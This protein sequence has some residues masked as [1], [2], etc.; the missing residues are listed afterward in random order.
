MPREKIAFIIQSLGIGGAE[1]FLIAIANHFYLFGYEPVIVLLS[2]QMNLLPEVNPGIRVVS[3]LK[4]ARWDI[5]VSFKIRDWL[6]NEG[7]GKVFCVNSYAFFLTKLA[8]LWKNDVRFFVSLHS[9]IPFSRKDYWLNMIYFRAISKKDTI[10]Y[11]CENQK[12]YLQRKYFFSTANAPVVYN[13]IDTTYFDPALFKNVDIGAARKQYLLDPDDKVI[14]QVA[15][16][17]AEKRHTDSI[18]ALA[19]LH[20]RFNIRAHLLLVGAG[21]DQYTRWI[22][23]YVQQKGLSNY[24]HFA[25]S[26]SDV[27]KFYFISD[28]FTLTS[29][30]ETFSLS[31]LEAMAFGL[32]CSLTSVGGAAEMIVDGVTG[33]LSEKEN[34]DSI[35]F[36][37]NALL[38]NKNFNKAKIRQFVQDNFSSDIMLNQYMALMK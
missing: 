17:Q 30:S 35:A 37:W 21:K 31:A 26:Q 28:A 27:R 4:K 11:L 9:T 22:Q 36:S 12:Q 3:F 23:A 8:F 15:R 38:E 1:K 10:I 14:V 18:D 34:P 5:R 24:V 25:G 13:G 2:D 29:N 32:P 7:I 6:R 19:V 20:T 33:V 16:L